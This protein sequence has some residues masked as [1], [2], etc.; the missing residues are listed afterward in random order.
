MVEITGLIGQKVIRK[1]L[2]KMD[3]G[4]NLN[5]VKVLYI[6]IVLLNIYIDI[7]VHVSM[8]MLIIKIDKY[9]YRIT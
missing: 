6:Y 4:R 9:V 7:Y 8:S 5:R 1:C 2:I 3:I